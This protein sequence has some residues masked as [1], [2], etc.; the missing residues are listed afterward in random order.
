MLCAP[1]G[2]PSARPLR[3]EIRI[4]GIDVRGLDRPDLGPSKSRLD[5]LVEETFV[6]VQRRR[7]DV[8]SQR[9]AAIAERGNPLPLSPSRDSSAEL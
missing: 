9:W 5:P 2:P 8:G 6:F 7:R 3:L 1:S 4:E